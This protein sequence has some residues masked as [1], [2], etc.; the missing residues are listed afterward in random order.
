MNAQEILLD[1]DYRF[2]TPEMDILFNEVQSWIWAGLSG[3]VVW[4]HSRAGKSSAA[5]YIGHRVKSRS[6]SKVPF[7]F[8]PTKSSPAKT[9]Q[10]FYADLLGS[11]RA[12][13]KDRSPAWKSLRQLLSILTDGA[14]QNQERQIL[15]CIDE[16]QWLETKR[17]RLLIDIVNELEIDDVHAFV[18]LVGTP[19]LTNTNRSIAG[20]KN[21]N[22]RG[23][24]FVRSTQFRGVYRKSDFDQIL[25]HFDDKRQWGGEMSATEQLLGETEWAGF[26][27]KELKD[28]LWDA[29]R[30]QIKDLGFS[31]WP[32]QFVMETIRYLLLEGI[33]ESPKNRDLYDL[34]IEAIENS[35]I[36][37]PVGDA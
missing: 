3:G 34:S 27:L 20:E 31:E 30:H 23:R 14:V 33:P 11:L 4:G 7:F 22:I 25:T 35:G 32:M 10:K 36:G 28:A 21:A 8:A 26:E 9:D 24:F 17:Y 19:D 37:L 5:K 12:P 29:Y 6:G 18:L 15:L 16:A 1:N 13:V 2:V